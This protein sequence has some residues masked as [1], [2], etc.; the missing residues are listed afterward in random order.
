MYKFCI[1]SHNKMV[2]K[3]FYDEFMKYGLDKN[4]KLNLDEVADKVIKD[5]KLD[6]KEKMNLIYHSVK[7]LSHELYNIVSFYPFQLNLDE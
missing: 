7:R 2:I 1:I 4:N 3:M 5:L 6:K